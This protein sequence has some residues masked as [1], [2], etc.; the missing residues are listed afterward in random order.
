VNQKLSGLEETGQMAGWN[1]FPVYRI[2]DFIRFFGLHW[3]QTSDSP[4]L[5]CFDEPLEKESPGS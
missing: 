3:V 4:F 1:I 2:M 5:N